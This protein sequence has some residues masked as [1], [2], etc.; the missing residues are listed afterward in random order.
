VRNSKESLLKDRDDALNE[1][2]ELGERWHDG[3]SDCNRRFVER[4]LKC[5]MCVGV[6][7]RLKE[8]NSTNFVAVFERK[9]RLLLRRA[10]GSACF[11]RGYEE[12]NVNHGSSGREYSPMLV[13]DVE[14]VQLPERVAIASTVRLHQTDDFFDLGANP[15]EEFCSALVIGQSRLIPTYWEIGFSQNLVVDIGTVFKDEFGSEAVE[16]A[17]QVVNDISDI[18]TPFGRHIFGDLDAVDFY[19]GFRLFIG[20]DSIGF[21]VSERFDSLCQIVKVFCGPV[22]LYPATEQRIIVHGEA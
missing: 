6:E 5:E 17:S 11:W 1:V 7:F 15:F 16:R 14:L 22:D 13:G 19:R 4:Y 8:N 9:G 18:P 12:F 2:V 3:L 20:P 21:A 10:D